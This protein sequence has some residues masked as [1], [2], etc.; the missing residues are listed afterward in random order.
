MCA[1]FQGEGWEVEKEDRRKRACSRDDRRLLTCVD[2]MQVGLR[3]LFDLRR[4]HVITVSVAC[5]P[6]CVWYL[7]RS[8]LVY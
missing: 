3:V 6:T 4:G 7:R 2:L 8:V 5:R 1:Q